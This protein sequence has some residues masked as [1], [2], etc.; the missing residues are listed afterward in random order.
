MI[1]TPE[2]MSPEVLNCVPYNPKSD[3]W[4]L[5]VLLYK[6]TM[7]QQPFTGDNIPELRETVMHCKYPS[8]TGNYSSGLK[9]IIQMC[10]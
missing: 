10:L 2:N 9:N 8:I 6:M 4:Q 3:I 7:L 1:G 5:G